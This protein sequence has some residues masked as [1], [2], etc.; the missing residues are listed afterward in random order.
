MNHDN[1]A[2][3]ASSDSKSVVLKN[4]GL[5]PRTPPN[6]ARCRNHGLKITL[7][8]HKRYCKYRYCICGKCTLTKDRQ[9][10]MALQTALRRA[11]DQDTTR[12]RRP[13]EVE[14]RP[15][16]LDGERLISVPQPARSLENSCDSNSAD[17]PFSNHGSTAPHNGIVT[18]PPSRKLPP[19]HNIHSPSATQLSEPR[20]CES[21]ENVEVLL[22]Y[23]AK[24]LEQFWYSWEILPLMYVI[25][26]DAKADL[27]E[28][29][30]RIEEANNEIRAIAVRKAR[31]MITDTGD[32]YYNEWYTATAGSGAPTYFGQPPHIGSF[33]HP[34][35]HLGIPHLLNA[36]VLAT[37]VPS[38]P[39]G[40]PTT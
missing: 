2:S 17:S 24:L 37:R 14:P 12:V 27:D 16:S 3:P 29:R 35:V 13:D 23:S 10:V 25:L 36:H 38:S 33:M 1:E 6:C 31:K 8:G 20:S 7:K 26:K 39:P 22:E 15:M 18:I 19:S 28:A 9:R 34:P 30:R 11:Q 4:A 5:I 21:S 40:G 32:G